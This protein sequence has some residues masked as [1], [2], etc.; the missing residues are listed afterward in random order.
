MQQTHCK[1]WREIVIFKIN[2]SGTT[3]RSS[4]DQM[5]G[6]SWE[7]FAKEIHAILE[8]SKEI[9]DNWEIVR[10][11]IIFLVGSLVDIVSSDFLIFYRMTMNVVF[12]WRR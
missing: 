6:I 1:Q 11:V 10:A 8:R 7:Q 2:F 4:A 5:D 9:V 3:S 12:T